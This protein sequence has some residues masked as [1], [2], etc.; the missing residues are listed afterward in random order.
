MPVDINTIS[1]DGNWDDPGKLGTV[2]LSWLHIPVST[3]N[4]SFSF[5]LLQVM[6]LAGFQLL[7][8][9]VSIRLC[10]LSKAFIL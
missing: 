3:R 5:S 6:L 10:F 7:A 8:V 9:P 4:G 2:W 1:E